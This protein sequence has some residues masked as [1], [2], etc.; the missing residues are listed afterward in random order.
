M[1]KV[2]PSGGT[3]RV[4]TIQGLGGQ[5]QPNEMGAGAMKGLLRD[6]RG[7]YPDAERITGIRTTGARVG[8]ATYGR[9]SQV[10]LR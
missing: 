10:P 3:L 4:E 2:V 6:L 8:G 9:P 1:V 7:F 5:L